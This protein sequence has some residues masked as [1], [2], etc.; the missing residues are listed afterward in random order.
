MKCFYDYIDRIV[1]PRFSFYFENAGPLPSPE[2]HKIKSLYAEDYIY[3]VYKYV[4]DT[5]TEG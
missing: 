5:A 4:Q 2:Q 3:I 1:F